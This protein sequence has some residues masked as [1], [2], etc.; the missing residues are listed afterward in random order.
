VFVFG[1]APTGAPEGLRHAL[2][3]GGAEAARVLE[4]ASDSIGDDLR[5]RFEGDEPAAREPS[6]YAQ[7][8][9]FIASHIRFTTLRRTIGDARWSL[10]ASLGEYNHLVHIGA[11]TFADAVRLVDARGRAFD[12]GPEGAMMS[13]VGV[14]TSTL[15]EVLENIDGVVEISLFDGPAHHVIAGERNA[16][17]IAK[18]ELE[19][20]HLARCVVLPEPR[21]AHCDLFEPAAD[22]L[23][24]ALLRAAWRVPQ[25][26]YFPNVRGEPLPDAST[27]D[28]VVA[29]RAQLHRP[30]LWG[31]S[32][33][34]IAGELRDADFVHVDACA[35]ACTS[36]RARR[37][38]T[39]PR[40]VI[41]PA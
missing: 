5:A 15:R 20:Y 29:L 9:A 10:G 4:E 11:L 31:Q 13:I 36:G 2:H 8:S 1:G 28:F 41:V 38:P 26:P 34:W 22:A 12:R 27:L 39:P 30:V 14:G 35:R 3:F 7:L 25:R 19:Q 40:R 21:P 23:E 16:V 24:P 33:A 18:L 17:R 32:L 37:L 6:R